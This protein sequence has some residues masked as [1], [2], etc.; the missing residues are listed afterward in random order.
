MQ[1]MDPTPTQASPSPVRRWSRAALVL[2][3]AAAFLTLLTVAVL[4]HSAPPEPGDRAPAFS[5]DLLEGG[6][7]A[8]GTHGGKP[9]VVNFWASW[10]VPCEDE[11]PILSRAHAEYRNEVDFVGINI[12]DA[13][14]EA[15]AFKDRTNMDYT[16]VRDP[17]LR[18][19]D[20]FGLTG[21]PETFFIDD[22]GVIVE[23][24]AGPITERFLLSTLELLVR[25][26]A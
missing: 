1:G 26:S 19:Y 23:H 10:C 24:V 11:A 12:R 8:S 6:S 21:Q 17:D 9:M 2:V 3:P 20:D 15:I 18:I 14:S 13:L 5:G 4:R 16:H 25:R 7:F 22:E